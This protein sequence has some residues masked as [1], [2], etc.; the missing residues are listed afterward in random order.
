M[1]VSKKPSHA[2]LSFRMEH[3]S[4]GHAGDVYS[5]LYR[6]GCILID[7]Q[8]FK[9]ANKLPLQISTMV[10]DREE[11]LMHIKSIRQWVFAAVVVGINIAILYMIAY[12][13]YIR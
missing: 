8:A 11:W 1:V 5:G 10:V 12:V 2:R 7:S 4:F 3:I 9:T 13:P 6:N